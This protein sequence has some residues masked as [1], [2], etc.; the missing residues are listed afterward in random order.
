MK[1]FVVPIV[2]ALLARTAVAQM[3]AQAWEPYSPALVARAQGG[4][5]AAQFA[6]AEA[7]RTGNGTAADREQAI[8][9]YRKAAPA[10]VR[11]ADA[12][13]VLLFTKGERKAAIPLLQA[14]ARHQNAYALYILGT[15]RFN[16]DYVPR[17]LAR[18]YAD[19]RIA[20]QTLPQAQ[21]SLAMMEPYVGPDDRLR[22]DQLAAQPGGSEEGAPAAPAYASA[23]PAPVKPAAAP[24]ARHPRKVA[25]HVPTD[26]PS[27]AAAAAVMPLPPPA[28]SPPTPVR[29][30]P[31][32]TAPVTG[33]AT[34]PVPLGDARIDDPAPAPPPLKS[35]AKAASKPAPPPKPAARAVQA[36]GAWRVQLG[37][38]GSDERAATQW[39]ALVA[40][41]PALA[42][43]HKATEPAGA[44]FRLQATGLPSKEA[45]TALCKSVTEGG[46]GCFVVP[47]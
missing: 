47:Q 37:A 25:A 17:D 21:R 27:T 26:A 33:S 20:A 2:A 3:P 24:P 19:M 45:A 15:A 44:V 12:L 31:T 14:S 8:S 6:L 18:A 34:D 29:A 39:K 30:T 9:W 38:Y 7:F 22:A 40:K 1:L 35:A 36:T 46:G 23:V 42:A 43:Y 11:A 5:T 28:W 10:D 32:R 41:V 13:G 16:G 4:E